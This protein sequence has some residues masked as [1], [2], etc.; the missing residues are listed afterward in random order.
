MAVVSLQDMVKVYGGGEIAVRGIDLEIPDK[1]FAV[2]VGP[3]GCGKTTTLRMVAGL[4]TISHGELRIDGRLVNS[5]PS[6]D[7]RVAMVFQSY[8]LYPHMTVRQNLEFSLKLEKLPERD[9]ADRVAGTISVLELDPYLDRRPSELSGG[10]RQ[11]VAMGRAIVREPQVFLFDEPLSNLDAQLRNQMRVE[12]KRLQKRLQVTT[13]YVTHDQ[14]EAMTLADIM[15]VMRDGRIE[16][17]GT[18]MEIFETPA[19][20]FV[21]GFIGSPRINFFDGVAADIDGR[22]SFA[23][24]HLTAPISPSRFDGTVVNGQRLIAGFRPED[25]VPEGHGVEPEQSVTIR[26]RVEFAEMLGNETLLFSGYGG[27]EFI[28]RMQRPRPVEPDETL[29]FRLN[30]D[31]MHLF[32]AETGD[33]VRP[34]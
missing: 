30:L 33:S 15:V 8:A 19:N 20:Q 3:S 9:I 7:R 26:S 23:N 17:T 28:S 25:I 24:E 18:P 32:D 5:L 34:L 6:R 29:T 1:A 12:I 10:Q 14:I 2:L 21:A 22:L 16:Q 4:E 11:R 27:R 13:I 31:R